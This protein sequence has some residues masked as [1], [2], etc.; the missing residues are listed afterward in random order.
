[1]TDRLIGLMG[2]D[3]VI[4]LVLPALLVFVGTRPAE[5]RKGRHAL[6]G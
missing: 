4:G 5:R 1:M 3:T 6:R 2:T